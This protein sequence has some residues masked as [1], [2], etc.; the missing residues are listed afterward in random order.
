MADKFKPFIAHELAHYYFGDYRNFN[1]EL[2]DMF[3]ESFSEYLP[4]KLTRQSIDDKTCFKNISKKLAKMEGK[5]FSAI[6]DVKNAADYGNRNLYVY[7]YA[8]IIWLAIEKEIGEEKMWQ[9]LHKILTVET[10]QTDYKFMI[11]TLASVIEKEQLDFIEETY[12]SNKNAV[13]NAN[14]ALQ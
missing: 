13:K 2:G 7:T 6:K 5:M 3:Q 12:L 8:A 1:S 9:W 10:E 4:L 14:T 11:K